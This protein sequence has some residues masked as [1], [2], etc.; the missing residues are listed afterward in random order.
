MKSVNYYNTFIEVAD[1]CPVDRAEIPGMRGAGKTIPLMQFEMI[2]EAPYRFTQD[3]VVFAGYAMK[4]QIALQ[5]Q[6]E[7]EKFFS[8]GQP[9]LRSSPLAKRYGWGF[10]C[11]EQ[12]RVAI[13]AVE[14]EAYK[15]LAGDEKLKR[16]KAMRTSRKK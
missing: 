2:S 11:D 16:L 14:S 9:C 8:R 7:R 3:D 15:K 10:H 1:D 13:Y 5:N 12:G 4:N 6:P